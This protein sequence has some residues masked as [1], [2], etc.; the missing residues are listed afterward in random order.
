MNEWQKNLEFLRQKEQELEWQKQ[1]ADSLP[2]PGRSLDEAAEMVG[3]YTAREAIARLGLPRSTFYSLVR[4]GVIPTRTSALRKQALYPKLIIDGL[5][6]DEARLH[7]NRPSSGHQFTFSRATVEDLHALLVSRFVFSSK[8]PEKRYYREATGRIWHEPALYPQ[9]K[10]A[11]YVLKAMGNSE[12]L[13][14]IAM[15]VLTPEAQSKV[16]HYEVDEKIH[17]VS[18]T[19]FLAPSDYVPWSSL[20]NSAV[21]VFVFDIFAKESLQQSHHAALLMRHVLKFFDVLLDTGVVVRSLYTLVEGKGTLSERVA[22]RF[23]FKPCW[24]DTLGQSIPRR[25]SMQP[26]MLRVFGARSS[27][28]LIHAYQRRE[29]A[30]QRRQRRHAFGGV[31]Q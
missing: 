7:G 17:G 23:G 20:A 26:F 18:V 3:C 8:H 31:Q 19:L 21:D 28:H 1:L 30:M 13:G 22:L 2:L 12:I 11:F 9:T 25:P 10:D 14:G 4:R 27:S 24:T 5:A 15:N 6:A 29:H 16:L